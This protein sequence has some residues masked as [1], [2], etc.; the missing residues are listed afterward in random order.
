MLAYFLL[1]LKIGTERNSARRIY[2]IQYTC[3]EKH[4]EK[5][6]KKGMYDIRQ[7]HN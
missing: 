4:G 6:S 3:K 7:Y 2:I 5:C 1:L